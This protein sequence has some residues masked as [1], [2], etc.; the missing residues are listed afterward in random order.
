MKFIIA[1]AIVF[2]IGIANAEDT[3]PPLPPEMVEMVEAEQEQ[4]DD[5]QDLSVVSSSTQGEAL[6]VW[7]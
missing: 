7:Q 1:F 3:P 4:N 6:V 5:K 2:S